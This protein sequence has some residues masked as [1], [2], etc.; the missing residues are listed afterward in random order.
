MFHKSIKVRTLLHFFCFLLQLTHQQGLLSFLGEI[1]FLKLGFFKLEYQIQ[2]KYWLYL[3]AP[4]VD[5]GS[6][7]NFKISLFFSK[8]FGWLY[9]LQDMCLLLQVLGF[10][11]NSIFQLQCFTTKFQSNLIQST[12]EQSNN[13]HGVCIYLL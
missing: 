6:L 1:I 2:P 7:M 11:L 4:P 12:E 9:F 10:I 8:H 5:F 13:I 3:L